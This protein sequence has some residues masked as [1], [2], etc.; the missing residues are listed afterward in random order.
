MPESRWTPEEIGERF[1]MPTHLV[2]HW[3]A[4]GQ[5]PA[6]V[7]ESDL[8]HL[9]AQELRWAKAGR[10]GEKQ[11]RELVRRMNEFHQR[12]ASGV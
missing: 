8:E 11:L 7:A 3:I 10:E 6:T 1:L 12:H 9:F 5:L 2:R 4:S